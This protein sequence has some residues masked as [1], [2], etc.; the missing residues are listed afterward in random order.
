MSV[1]FVTS[2]SE[3]NISI[4]YLMVR[5]RSLDMIL[6]L[7]NLEVN[8]YGLSVFIYVLYMKWPA[9]ALSSYL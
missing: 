3:L 5:K 4:I 1:K 7:D 9:W 6:V 2:A 8:S